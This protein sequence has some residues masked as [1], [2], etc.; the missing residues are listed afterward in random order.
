MKKYLILLIATLLYA[1]PAYAADYF[2]PISAGS[3]ARMVR[4]GHIE[5]FSNQAHSVFD[6][7]A[8]LYRIDKFSTSLF[9]TTFMEDVVYQNLSVAYRMPYGVLGVGYSAVGVNGLIAT[10][11]RLFDPGSGDPSDPYQYELIGVNTFDYG[12]RMFKIG[13]QFPQNDFISW[14]IGATYYTS[15]ISTLNASGINLDAGVV[16]DLDPLSF[17]ATAKNLMPG[18]GVAYSNGKSE[19]LP[20]DVTVG[21]QYLLQDVELLGQLKFADGTPRKL[22]QAY[23]VTYHPEFLPFITLSGGYSEVA[24]IRDIRKSYTAGIGFDLDGIS[25]DYAYETSDNVVYNSKHYF[26]LGFSL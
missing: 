11:K 4:V 19:K 8:G 22:L 15:T 21:V 14:G 18:S 5:G 7:P 26:S 1:L 9:T 12:N 3:S 17:S 24:V 20:L 10:E 2:M 23:G 16:V 13:Y 6:N 25:F